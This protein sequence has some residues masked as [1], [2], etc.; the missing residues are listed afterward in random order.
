M[1]T[2]GNLG[3]SNYHGTPSIDPE[4]KKVI[5]EASREAQRG[6]DAFNRDKLPAWVPK[7]IK[8]NE[9]RDEVSTELLSKLVKLDDRVAFVEKYAPRGMRDQDRMDFAGIRNACQ[10]TRARS[11]LGFPMKKTSRKSI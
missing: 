3:Q 5:I 11:R 8:N 2:L 9:R 10:Y 4:L 1:P 7:A 6:I